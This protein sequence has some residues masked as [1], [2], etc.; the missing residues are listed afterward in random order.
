[1][2]VADT[3]DGDFQARHPTPPQPPRRHTATPNQGPALGVRNRTR[4]KRAPNRRL[5]MRTVNTP[6]R[7]HRASAKTAPSSQNLVTPM[8]TAVHQPP[9]TQTQPVTTPSK[10]PPNT[11]PLMCP[12]C[13]DQLSHPVALPCGHVFCQTC[14]NR[15]ATIDSTGHRLTCPVCRR[16]FQMKRLI[17]LFLHMFSH[18]G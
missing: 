8:D 9:P 4:T 5:I 17:R 6:L 13:R 1:M 10:Q 14:I 15:I 11:F 18:K 7:H 2:L 12:V 3:S 16:R